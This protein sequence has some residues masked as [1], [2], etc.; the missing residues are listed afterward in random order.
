MQPSVPGAAGGGAG[1]GEGAEESVGEVLELP[2]Q[3]KQKRM[4]GI[5]LCG[6]GMGG[7]LA[8]MCAQHVPNISRV[9][10]LC[11]DSDPVIAPGA[12]RLLCVVVLVGVAASACCGQHLMTMA[13]V[14][15]VVVVFSRG[16]VVASSVA[17]GAVLPPH[18]L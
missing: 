4:R 5:T 2:G 3:R 6:V 11:S 7:W 10:M 14:V 17:V 1:G 13:V 16:C 12:P 9:V 8:L 18:R 15:V